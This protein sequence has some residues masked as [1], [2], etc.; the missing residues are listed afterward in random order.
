MRKFLVM[1]S[2][3]MLI[4]LTAG[5]SIAFALPATMKDS[6]NADI[7]SVNG[8]GGGTDAA[9]RYGTEPQTPSVAEH[10][11]D[12]PIVN[13]SY[14]PHGKFTSDT[15]A[16]GRCHQLHQA[17]SSRLIRFNV[18][19]NPGGNND[20]YR[21]CTYCHNFNGQ[22][23]YDVKDGMIWDAADKVRYATNGGGFERMLVVEGPAQL[24]TLVNA[25][26]SHQVNKA[27]NG[28]DYIRFNAPGADTS[29]HIT[30]KCSSCHNPH[31]SSNARV[32]VEKIV[33]TDTNGANPQTVNTVTN[34]PE[35]VTDRFANEKSIYPDDISNFCGACHTDY[36][37]TA[38]DG[39]TASGVS[40]NYRHKINMAADN[41]LNK[42]KDLGGLDAR[43]DGSFGYIDGTLQLPLGTVS[44]NPVGAP[45]TVNVVVCTSCHF[46]HGTGAEMTK[47]VI[48]NTTGTNTAVSTNS[49]GGQE[50]YLLE[51]GAGNIKYETIKNLRMDNRAVCQNCHN[52]DSVD[53]TAP[54][55]SLLLNPA[56]PGGYET[57]TNADTIAATYAKVQSA[58]SNNYVTLRFNQYMSKASV[59]AE[60]NYQIGGVGLETIG[61]AT[62]ELQ[63]DG[64]TV[65]LTVPTTT[66]ITA[67]VT[68]LT[69]ETGVENINTTNLAGNDTQTIK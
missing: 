61:S 53:A 13:N 6:N 33:Y 44:A 14:G 17:K 59:E 47:S 12:T 23:T 51:N 63:P 1:L 27:L 52:R 9:W 24:A 46:A 34:M 15:N 65:L 3:S 8:V 43:N 58:G 40:G 28:T 5:A 32:L 7:N 36:L 50:F 10:S 22:S 55:L 4:L 68:T 41:G 38:G 30:L 66:T 19:G 20:I 35:Y 29:R 11:D 16:C 42:D 69:V 54:A 48:N 67:N 57:Y 49:A 26:S 45:G 39:S 25:N 21:I 60:A 56:N 62:A 37:N 18:S 2:L 64:R 31:G